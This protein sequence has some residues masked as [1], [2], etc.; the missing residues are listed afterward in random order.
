[1]YLNISKTLTFL[2]DF[3]PYLHTLNTSLSSQNIK[4]VNI[5]I[6]KKYSFR[7]NI[8]VFL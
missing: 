4:K 5:S 3:N 6:L 1:M 8:L 2:G 7:H